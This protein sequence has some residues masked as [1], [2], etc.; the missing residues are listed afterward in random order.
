MP[1]KQE[2]QPFN[3]L[4][5]HDRRVKLTPE[6][7]E[8]IKLNPENLSQRK[9]AK[10]MNVSRRTIQFIRNPKSLEANLAS[11]EARGGW[12]HYYDKEKHRT[13][14]KDHRG[15]KESIQGR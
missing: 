10:L 7:R 13:Y 1:K 12:K 11:R 3:L 4:P 6:Q 14:M 15:Y 5:Q 8:Y 9:L 2:T